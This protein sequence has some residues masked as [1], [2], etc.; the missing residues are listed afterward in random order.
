MYR[1]A[2]GLHMWMLTA[3]YMGAGYKP[4]DYK[5]HLSDES[6]ATVPYGLT[7]ALSRRPACQVTVHLVHGFCDINATKASITT[8]PF[9]CRMC[10]PSSRVAT[11]RGLQ[12]LT[13]SV[14]EV[15]LGHILLPKANMD[16]EVILTCSVLVSSAE[17]LLIIASREGR[18]CVII[19]IF[20]VSVCRLIHISKEI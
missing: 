7:V 17:L 13:G 8:D 6:G 19:I 20:T 3:L 16:I 5:L 2:V 4:V 14:L 10:F 1:M 18:A 12:C 9:R 15:K 11:P